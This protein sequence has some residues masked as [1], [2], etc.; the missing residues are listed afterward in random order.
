MRSLRFSLLYL[1]TFLSLTSAAPAAHVV[2]DLDKRQTNP[3]APFPVTGVQLGQVLPRYEIRDLEQNQPDQFN[4]YLLGLQRMQSMNQS[5][6]LS[7]YQISGIHGVPQIPWNDVPGTGN[8]NNN[9]GYCTHISNIFLPWHRPYLAL[10]EQLLIS[11]AQ[12]VANEFAPGPVRD[13]YLTAAATLRIPYW[14]WAMV[15]PAGENSIPPS[16]TNPNATVITPNGTQTI[17]NPLYQY[18]FHPVQGLMYSPVSGYI[19]SR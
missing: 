9:P 5:D 15:P 14:D 12:T 13:S 8:E 7:W 6:M 1:I 18:T 3:N 11:N 16:M 4:V 2:E 10:Y 19:S 17:P